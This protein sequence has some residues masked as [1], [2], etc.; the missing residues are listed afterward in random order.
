MLKSNT[1]DTNE[2]I[3]ITSFALITLFLILNLFY[4]FK[5]FGVE[6]HF[7]YVDKDIYVSWL[8]R[9]INPKNYFKF[10]YALSIVLLPLGSIFLTTKLKHLVNKPQTFLMSVLST[11]TFFL[12]FVY[13][14]NYQTLFRIGIVDIISLTLGI[15]IYIYSQTIHVFSRKIIPVSRQMTD[16]LKSLNIYLFFKKI[17]RHPKV[18]NYYTAL[19]KLVSRFHFRILLILLLVVLINFAYLIETGIWINYYHHNYLIATINDLIQGKH[20]LVDTF[21]QYGLF[22][23]LLFYLLFITIAPF[24]YMN[25]YLLLMIFTYIYYVILY[26]FLKKLSKNP[27]ITLIGIYVILGVNTLFNYPTFPFSENYVWPGSTP[28][29]FFFDATVF[30]IILNNSYFRSFNLTILSGFLLAYA[31]FHNLEMGISLAAAYI[32]IIFINSLFLSNT[33]ISK[34]IQLFMRNVSPFLISLA[35]FFTGFEIYT[36]LVSGKLPDWSLLWD[37]IAL[38]QVGFTSV[39]TPKIGWYFIHFYIYFTTLILTVYHQIKDRYFSW[40]WTVLGAYALYGLLIL[41]YYLSRSYYSNLT[42]VSI[43]ALI[44]FITFFSDINKRKYSFKP[45]N[46]KIIYNIFI[47]VLVI[48]VTLTSYFLYKR[49]KYRVYSWQ[50]LQKLE[51]YSGN[52][53]FVVENFIP[54][55]GYASKDLL[56]SVNSIKKLTKNE[57]KI[58]LISKYD[59][60][61]LI[62]SEK[63]NIISFPLLE[64]IHRVESLNAVKKELVSRVDKPKYLFVDKKN[65][66]EK[67]S[68]LSAPVD[69]LEDIFEAISPFY[70]FKEQA[71]ILDIYVLKTTRDYL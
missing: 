16:L 68:K 32:F 22:W 30:L 39:T 43:P 17:S 55:K 28:I 23:P 19:I 45:Q 46:L 1:E 11:L 35:L 37:S 18:N 50:Q 3:L 65:P 59:A 29:R 51:R 58:L 34:R 41:N 69:V 56:N 25:L 52:R 24:S 70:E 31:L 49:L 6:N 62:M 71:G 7:N 61:I 20:I 10:F 38:Y 5:L 33:S 4:L 48:L 53:G 21:N 64:Q 66:Y 60:V 8:H 47:G 9:F 36:F 14:Q 42:V 13:L 40:K 2:L 44:I 12:V 15:G 57:K 27:V 54:P 63:T 26:F 67:K